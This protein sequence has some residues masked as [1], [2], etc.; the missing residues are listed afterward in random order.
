MPAV[1][2]GLVIIALAV[3]LIVY[4]LTENALGAVGVVVLIAGAVTSV[5]ALGYSATPDKFGPSEAM[6]RL[7]AGAVAAD[8][9]VVLLLAAFTSLGAVILV[10]IF[11]IILAV[12]GISVALI[13]GKEGK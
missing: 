3:G 1:T 2:L 4:Y 9:G 8:V 5:L 13:N 12:V 11:L 10:A 6:Y 7:A